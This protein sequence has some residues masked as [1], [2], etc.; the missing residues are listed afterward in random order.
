MP[1]FLTSRF[2]R[3]KQISKGVNQSSLL[4]TFIWDRFQ[5]YDTNSKANKEY[6]IYNDEVKLKTVSQNAIDTQIVIND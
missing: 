1:F 5:V 3:K 4:N 6:T 2:Q